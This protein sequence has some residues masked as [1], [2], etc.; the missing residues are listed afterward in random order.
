MSRGEAKCLQQTGQR[1]TDRPASGNKI[2]N[3]DLVSRKEFQLAALTLSIL[4]VQGT[5]LCARLMP[6]N[7]ARNFLCL[8]GCCEA[9]KVRCH[10]LWYTTQQ[11]HDSGHLV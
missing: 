7:K 11:T 9:T 8:A 4:F 10:Q 3:N 5:N 2:V 1:Q 6:K